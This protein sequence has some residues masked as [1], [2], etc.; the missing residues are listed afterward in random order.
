MKESGYYNIETL[1]KMTGLT[2]RTIRY[3]VQC[4]LLY[5]PKGAGRGHYYTTEHLTRIKEILKLQE[6]GF[7]LNKMKELFSGA[8]PRIVETIDACAKMEERPV[9]FRERYLTRVNIG[10][11]I[12]FNFRPDLLNEEDVRKIQEFISSLL[13][14]T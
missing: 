1:A 5:P 10:P 14:R 4:H 13:K 12:E 6:Q 7:P 3:Y 2:R 11:E 8:E 9:E